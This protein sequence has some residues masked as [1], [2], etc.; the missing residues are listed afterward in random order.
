[1]SLVNY[2]GTPG[3]ILYGGKSTP[4]AGSVITTVTLVNGSGTATPSEF[5]PKMFGLPLKKGDMPSG[6]YPSF[7][8]PGDIPCAASFGP[9]TF[10]PDGSMRFVPVLLRVPTSLAG[11]SSTTISVKNGGTAPSS[12][13]LTNAVITSASD[14]KVSATAFSNWTVGEWISSVNQG[15]TDGDVWTFADGAAGRVVRVYEGFRRSGADHGQA[16]MWHY[17]QILQ[18]GSSGL[19]GLRHIGKFS[20]GWHD[21]ASPAINNLTADSVILKNGGTNIRTITP[22]ATPR[23][24][25]WSSGFSAADVTNLRSGM[26]VKL[27][28]TGTLPAGLSATSAYYVRLTGGNAFTLHPTINDVDYANNE[29]VATS[30]GTGTH[31]L[32][33][34]VQIEY[35]AAGPYTAGTSTDFDFVQ[36]GGT[37]SETN[38]VAT[39]DRAYRK[40]TRILGSI[41]TDISPTTVTNRD[42]NID[43]FQDLD[44]GQDGTG[45]RPD[46]GYITA[47]C[48]R[49]F[50]TNTGLQALRVH[51][52]QQA[53]RSWSLRRLATKAPINLTDGA[54]SGMGAPMSGYRFFPGN[55]AA[56][57]GVNGVVDWGKMLGRFDWSH[58]PHMLAYVY[59]VCG[60]PQFLDALTDMANAGIASAANSTVTVSGT[61]YASIVL[62]DSFQN[63]TEAWIFRDLAFAVMFTPDTYMG[64][65]LGTYFKDIMARNL[66]FVKAEKATGTS[67]SQTNKFYPGFNLPRQGPWQI[68]YLLTAFN[69][70]YT[71]TED[72]DAKTAIEDILANFDAIRTNKGLHVVSNY[73]DFMVGGPKGITSWAGLLFSNQLTSISY[74]SSTLTGTPLPGVGTP[75][76]NS[77][78][79]FSDITPGDLAQNTVY[80]MR[81]VSG[82]TFKVSSTPGGA[83]LTMTGSGSIP[84]DYLYASFAGVSNTTMANN[85]GE[86]DIAAKLIGS[87]RW[88]KA[89][90]TTVPSGL[91][92]ALSTFY[93]AG[94][95]FTDDC[96]Y[97]LD[98]SF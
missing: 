55:T 58:Q 59:S 95:T 54:Y 98:T 3:T 10:W 91:D 48:T 86:K 46:I 68:T 15:I 63:R 96:V 7:F 16:G 21:V 82:S 43:T 23:A 75:A 52:Y 9:P 97:A 47:W 78:V 6:Q 56:N 1:M 92:T 83:A 14:L 20:N 84:D 70:A 38:V 60:E 32:T 29:I 12:S 18:N 19:F 28:T 5:F 35:Y 93:G 80:Y 17:V 53:G 8:L 61:P 13:A 27:T 30:A 74:S 51:C 2:P 73:Y 25:T 88:S 76:N 66:D 79:L 72:P 49:H 33:P 50:V 42:Y 37:G 26:A 22:K 87:V 81:D 24:F 34:I 94:P 39:V 4:P 71:A 65:P 45:E 69:L 11:S 31:T 85:A 44:F 67:F 90:G 62:R 57:S 36:A 89:L 64:A 40:A 77:P 41:R